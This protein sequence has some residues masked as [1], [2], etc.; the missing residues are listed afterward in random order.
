MSAKHHLHIAASIPPYLHPSEVIAALQ[1][2][3]TTLTLQA[4]TT[5]HEKLPQ[6]APETLKDTYWYPT[7]INPVHTYSVTECVTVL[8]GIGQWGRKNMTFP[9]CYQDIPTGIKTRADAS[10]VTVRADYRVIKGGVDGQVEGEGQGIG[11]AEWVLVEDAEV[12]C[13]WWLMPFVKGKMEQAHRD[14]C[15]KVIEK[16]EMQR[17][18][19]DLA[20]FV[21]RGQELSQGCVLHTNARPVEANADEAQRVELPAPGSQ[22]IFYG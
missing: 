8:P 7:D 13:S 22:K 5:G 10:G 14:I 20:K 2:H 3:N 18:Q 15:R 4:L 9:S 12:S 1:D 6:T 16:V 21:G 19:N 17:R 11:D